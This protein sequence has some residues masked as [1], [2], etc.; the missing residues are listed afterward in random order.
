MQIDWTESW[1][2]CLIGFHILLTTL[3]ITTRH[4]HT[5]QGL[6]FFLLLLTVKCSEIINEYAATHWKRFS[7]QQYF[8][9]GGLFISVVFSMPVLFNCLLMVVSISEI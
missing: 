6:L 4:H 5:L 3:T 1:L 9:S 7:Y 8:D 2:L